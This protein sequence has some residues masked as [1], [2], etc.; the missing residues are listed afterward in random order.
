MVDM[1]QIC[2]SFGYFER[3]FWHHKYVIFCAFHRKPMLTTTRFF[4]FW[5]STHDPIKT[6]LGNNS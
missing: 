2:Q 3:N 4:F 5:T 6:Y 1:F